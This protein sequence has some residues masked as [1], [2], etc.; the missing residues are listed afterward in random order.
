M[1]VFNG[2]YFYCID[3]NEMDMTLNKKLLLTLLL[4]LITTSVLEGMII[5]SL[6]TCQGSS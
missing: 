1:A 4:F 2:H 6:A 5:K 3:N